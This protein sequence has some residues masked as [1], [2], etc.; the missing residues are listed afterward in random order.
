M[1]QGKAA[2][3]WIVAVLLTAGLL[4]YQRRTGP[5]YPISLKE[6]VGTGT[7]SGSLI[8]TH[9]TTGPA[10]ISVTAS[11]G[12]GGELVWRRFPTEDPWTRTPMERDGEKLKA[13]LPLLPAAGKAE[14]VVEVTQGEVK[15]DFPKDGTAILRYKGA[16]PTWLLITH[17][18][19]MFLAPIMAFRTAIGILMKEEN[20]AKRLWWLLGFMTV[21]GFILGPMM[22][23][24]AF[25]AL[26]TGWPVGEDLTDSKTLAAYVGWIAASVFAF[27]DSKWKTHAFWAALIV[28][29]AVYLIPH[30]VRGSQVDWSKVDSESSPASSG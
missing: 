19:F 13:S 23:Q 18:I 28:M 16:V 4:V 26:W 15:G 27:K 2:I 3:A 1:S 22:Q 20:W 12:I 7:V 24:Y 8:R 17:V 5:T 29:L 11:E 21:G 10:E 9:E 25:G 30:S 14:Y 6:T